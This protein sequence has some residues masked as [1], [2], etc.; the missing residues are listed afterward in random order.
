MNTYITVQ[1]DLSNLG[2]D[3]MRIDPPCAR[4]PVSLGRA[5][6]LGLVSGAW[7]S[8]RCAAMPLAPMVG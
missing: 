2:S 5:P 7:H 6:A 1:M 8:M 4:P 3:G